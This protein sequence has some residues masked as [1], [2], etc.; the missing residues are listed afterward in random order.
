MCHVS[1]SIDHIFKIELDYLTQSTNNSAKRSNGFAGLVARSGS[2]MCF[3]KKDKR[4]PKPE[5]FAIIFIHM[6]IGQVSRARCLEA[7]HHNQ[8][9]VPSSGSQISNMDHLIILFLLHRRQL[10]STPWEG[11]Q[12]YSKRFWQFSWTHHVFWQQ[13]EFLKLTER[14]R[15][16]LCSKIKTWNWCKRILAKLAK[17]TTQSRYIA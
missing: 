3:E 5:F 11:T 2:V 16:N 1:K 17:L 10:D 15:S 13:S 9:H 4:S 6:T 8:H 14:H 7:A 12:C